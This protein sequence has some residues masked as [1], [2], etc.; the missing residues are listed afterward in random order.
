MFYFKRSLLLVGL[1]LMVC[2]AACGTASTP[3]ATG[4]TN[5]T[6]SNTNNNQGTT[7]TDGTMQTSNATPASKGTPASGGM[8]PK[9]PA[10]T[11]AT[12][13]PAGN[14]QT[15]FIKTTQ[16]KING[17]LL[18]VL[19]NAKGMILYYKLNDPRPASAC[20]GA[21]AQS[22]PPVLAQGM[23]MISSS[24]H[25]PHKLAVYMTANGNQVEYDGHPLYTYVGDMT[26]GQ[27]AGRGMGM[28]WYL[29]STAL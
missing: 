12:T 3:T 24:M 27:F 29:V 2:L 21:C 22:W 14:M 1:L 26:P 23:T 5:N 8:T 25:L 10:V 11:P 20:T 17:K 9:Y 4:S 15:A 28:V 19:T 16:V 7:K 6:M 13:M 18:V